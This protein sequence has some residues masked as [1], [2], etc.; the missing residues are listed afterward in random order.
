MS[1]PVKLVGS[2]DQ[3]FGGLCK[4]G[5]FVDIVPW[6]E[7]VHFQP[8][9][10][11]ISEYLGGG[12]A[13]GPA[14]WYRK[15]QGITVTGSGVSQWSDASGNGRHLLQGTDTNRPA[16]QTDGTILFDGVDNYLQTAA[17]TLN[18]PTTVYFLG[19]QVTWTNTDTICDGRTN[20]SGN[21]YQSTATPTIKANA[22][23]DV[24]PANGLTLDTY[25]TVCAVF[26]GASSSLGV[27]NGV[28]FTGATGDAGAGNM[29]GFTLGA[30]GGAANFGNIRVKEVMIFNQAHTGAQQ[31]LILGYLNTL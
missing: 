28:L 9:P 30:L 22:G 21:I 11:L 15:G 16:L 18:Q 6:Q 3:A 27:S 1:I 19:K 10:M 7:G 12:A 17:F 20:A 8:V 26:N 29:G 13:Q 14:A 4:R 24:G 2:T 31:S 23:S 5:D 25:K